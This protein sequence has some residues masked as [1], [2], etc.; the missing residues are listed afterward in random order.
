MTQAAGVALLLA[1]L[2]ITVATAALVALAAGVRGFFAPAVAV[3]VL[4]V[5]EVTALTELLSLL[6]GI[7]RWQYLA[8]QL[9][10]PRSC[11]WWW[12]RRGRPRPARPVFDLRGSLLVL[13]LGVVVGLAVAYEAFLVSTTPPNTWIDGVPPAACGRVV[14]ARRGRVPAGRTPSG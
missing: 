12:D 9:V 14:P 5:A 3:Y 11:P 4:G 13:T 8:C 2:G 6:H 10:R 7:G 1:G